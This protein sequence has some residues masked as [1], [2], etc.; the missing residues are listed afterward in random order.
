MLWR[1][2]K[3]YCIINIIALVTHVNAYSVELILLNARLNQ[4]S[5][6][7]VKKNPKVSH[8]TGAGG[9]IWVPYREAAITAPLNT[10]VFQG[11]GTEPSL[12]PEST[13]ES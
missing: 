10:F 5:S 4:G 9:E 3:N 7:S 12:A 8:S 1:C 11:E 6:S 2:T 13:E